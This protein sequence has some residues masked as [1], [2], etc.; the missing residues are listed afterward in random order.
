M[1]VSVILRDGVQAALDAVL[2]LPQSFLITV[3]AVIVVA[4]PLSIFRGK[5]GRG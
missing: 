5:E 1:P 4:V 2:A 3:I